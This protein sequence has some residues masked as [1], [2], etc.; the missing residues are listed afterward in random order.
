MTASIDP[1]PVPADLHIPDNYVSHTLKTT[2][3]L[4]PVTLANIHKEINWL[5]FFILT[6]PPLIGLYGALN[7]KLVLPTFIWA[8][9]YYYM[10]GLGITAGYHRLWAHRSYNAGL[11]LQYALAILGSGALEGSIK[12]WSRGHRAHHRYTDTDLDPYNA[13]KGKI[14]CYSLARLVSPILR[15]LLL[16]HWLDARQTPPASWCRRR[17]GFV[18]VPCGQ[19]AAPTLYPPYPLHGIHLPNPCR[20]PR[21]G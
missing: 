17:L 11:P 2:K 6:V 15:L 13:H 16:S 4:P 3:P 7:V 1:E 12:W 9:V 5:S 10:T 20:W 19:V 18:K 14:P 8:V 21:L